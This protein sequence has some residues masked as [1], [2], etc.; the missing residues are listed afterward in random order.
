MFLQ[1]LDFISPKLTLNFN[2][3]KTHSSIIS[4]ILTIISY[5][6]IGIFSIYT[7]MD[8]IL[9]K[10]PTAYSFLNV[11]DD[12][13]TYN[14]NSSGMFHYIQF[15]NLTDIN[16]LNYFQIIGLKNSYTYALHGKREITDHYIYEYCTKDMIDS[17]NINKIIDESI[18]YQSLCISKFYNSTSKITINYNDKNFNFPTIEHGASNK[19][20]TFYGIFI[21]KCQN[22]SLNNYSCAS[23]EEIDFYSLYLTIKFNVISQYINVKNYKN[24][25]VSF[26]YTLT[27]GYSDENYYTLNSLN[28]EPYILN[29]DNG[30]LFNNL[31][32]D[33]SYYFSQNDKKSY[34][35]SYGIICG[36]YFW[37]Q[38]SALIYE[39]KYQKIQDVLANIGGIMKVLITFTRF[40]N[41]IFYKYQAYKDIN[42]V[43]N[44]YTNEEEK[45]KNKKGHFIPLSESSIINSRNNI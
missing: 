38:N 25:F 41:N 37:M 8:L 19:N 27:D 4:G 10:N 16:I 32:N 15:V 23:E 40:I 12:V 30:F 34:E 33:K 36:I 6:L 21:Q 24:P 39:R 31:Y 29:T 2:R 13:G 35:T 42:K 1:K 45:N 14:L 22:S 44:S 18:Y 43:I 5:T 7:S 9:K 3:Q 28:F 20:G 26:I 11:I 17:S